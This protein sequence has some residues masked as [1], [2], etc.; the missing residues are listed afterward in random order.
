M[1]LVI[2]MKYTIDALANITTR[3]LRYYDS[4]GLLKAKR[5]RQSNYRYYETD[6]VDRLQKILFLKELDVPLKNIAEYLATSKE[7]ELQFLEQHLA[8]VEKEEER[9]RQLRENIQKT[10]FY[11]KGEAKMH[12]IE[13]FKGLKGKLIEENEKQY[14][15]EVVRRWGEDSY[16][17]SKDFF[18]N[19]SETQFKDHQQL[20]EEII[21]KLLVAFQKGNDP[22]SEESQHVAKLHQEWIRLSW[23]SYNEE[24]HLNLVDMYIDDARFKEYYDSHQAGLAQLLHD[25]VYIM[26][27][28]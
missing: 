14:K 5:D 20:S 7:E 4:I 8:Q 3:T 1:I 21:Q 2:K 26:L 19:M 23:G 16:E 22:R 11:Q 6:E 15:E 27:M 12:D 18:K 9:L 25:A 28:K 17:K 13:K 24:A 10:I